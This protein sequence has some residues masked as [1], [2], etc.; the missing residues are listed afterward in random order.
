M[1]ATFLNKV[2]NKADV[3][4]R[5]KSTS[6]KSKG[7]KT[8]EYR[9]WTVVALGVKKLQEEIDVYDGLLLTEGMITNIFQRFKTYLASL[10]RKV[11]DWLKQSVKNI[12]EFFDLEPEISLNE[13]IDFSNL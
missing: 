7:I 2:V 9:Y 6:I 13:K 12:I 1:N 11:H 3:T 4:V 10:F 5:F 8:G